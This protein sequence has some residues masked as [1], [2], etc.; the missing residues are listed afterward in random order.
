[1]HSPLETHPDNQDKSSLELGGSALQPLMGCLDPRI[2]YEQ[3]IYF[4][5]TMTWIFRA[6][7]NA[8]KSHTMQKMQARM[9]IK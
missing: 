5:E 7:P 4:Q 1:M 2:G 6:T 8:P 9:L 3:F